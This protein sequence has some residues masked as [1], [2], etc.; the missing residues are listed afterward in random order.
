MEKKSERRLPIDGVH[1]QWTPLDVVG[2]RLQWPRA[3][4]CVGCSTNTDGSSV[5]CFTNSF[6]V[7]LKRSHERMQWQKGSFVAAM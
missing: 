6:Q 3:A 1:K 4:G 5:N 7:S 2:H